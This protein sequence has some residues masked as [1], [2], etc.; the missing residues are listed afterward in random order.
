[1]IDCN[2]KQAMTTRLFLRTWAV[3]LMGLLF[4][5]ATSPV[6][7]AEKL[8]VQSGFKVVKATTPAQQQQMA[9]L[10]P[11][12]VTS[13]TRQGQVYYVFPDPVRNQLYVGKKAQYEAYQIAVQDQYL[14]QDARLQQSV[15]RAPVVN[16][17][18]AVMSGAE[19]GWEQIWEGWPAGE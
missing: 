6:Q 9:K 13:V 14:A 5:C 18:A 1:M 15:E 12:K 2:R 17:D 7:R 16:E 4:G 11:A 8:L 19:P 3:V 10:P